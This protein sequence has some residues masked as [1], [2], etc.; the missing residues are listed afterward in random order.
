MSLETLR[1]QLPDYAKD[2]KLNLGNLAND[3]PQASEGAERLATSIARAL[4]LEDAAAHRA[5]LEAFA[6]PELLGD[7]GLIPS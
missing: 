1:E 4:F 6:E 7:E 3:I 2:T 5:A